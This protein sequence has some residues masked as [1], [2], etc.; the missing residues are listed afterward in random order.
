MLLSYLD[1]VFVF[2]FTAVS[3]QAESFLP[4]WPQEK[5]GLFSGAVLRLFINS[6]SQGSGIEQEPVSQSTAIDR[7]IELKTKAGFL[8]LY[9][10]CKEINLFI[11]LQAVKRWVDLGIHYRRFHILRRL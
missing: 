6:N 2:R 1:T 11:G 4:N 9:M 3:H 8:H 7:H 5:Q 10:G